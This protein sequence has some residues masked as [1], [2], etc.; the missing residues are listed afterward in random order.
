MTR[1]LASVRSARFKSRPFDQSCLYP[2]MLIISKSFT[3]CLVQPL[4]VDNLRPLVN[5]VI[6]FHSPLRGLKPR[7]P[8]LNRDKQFHS[9]NSTHLRFEMANHVLFNL[10]MLCLTLVPI[11]L[12]AKEFSKFGVGFSLSLDYGF[13]TPFS[14]KDGR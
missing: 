5:L 12:G 11:A 13:T 1:S 3:Y 7:M 10:L 8:A 6:W 4:S 14:A 9:N 2:R